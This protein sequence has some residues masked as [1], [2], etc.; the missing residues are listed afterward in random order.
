[1]WFKNN[2]PLYGKLYDDFRIADV[3]SGNTIWCV[4]PVLGYDSKSGI[5][6]ASSAENNFEVPIYSAKSWTEL[7]TLIKESK[8]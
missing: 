8:K 1:V 3:E 7:L 2:C 5:A 4:S 6:E